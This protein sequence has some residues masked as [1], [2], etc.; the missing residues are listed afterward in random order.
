[1]QAGFLKKDTPVEPIPS[2]ALEVKLDECL[3][4]CAELRAKPA[5]EEEPYVFRYEEREQLTQLLKQAK[6]NAA[7]EA[8]TAIAAAAPR[9][10]AIGGVLECWIG[11]NFMDTEELGPAQGRLEAAIEA[12]GDAPAEGVRLIDALNHLGILWANRGE[13][14]KALEHL[15]RAE[16]LHRELASGGENGK[17]AAALREGEQLAD[18]HTLTC[19]YL[20]QA[21]GGLGQRDHSAAYCHVTM[22][23]LTCPPRPPS[24]TGTPARRGHNTSSTATTTATATA[25]ANATADATANA[26]ANATATASQP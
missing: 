11:I 20:A 13:S 23:V 15:T 26:N 17:A 7:A 3:A 4:A 18:L 16:A 21:Y 22:Q 1:M 25:T 6:A 2:D 8:G 14:E 19:F 24:S 5:S 9:A 10:R 12:L